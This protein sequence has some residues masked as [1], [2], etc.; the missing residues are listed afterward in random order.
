[1]SDAFF[2]ASAGACVIDFRGRVLAMR[3]RNVP[4]SA[5]Q[6]PQGGITSDELPRDAV[7][8]ELREEAGILPGEVE[9][10]AEHDAWLVY[11]VPPASRNAKVGWG[12]AQRWFLLRAKPGLA[13]VPDG[14]EF[15][16]CEWLTPEELLLR[17]VAFRKPIYSRAFWDFRLLSS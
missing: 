16:T 11:E 5:W 3:R 12:Q 1:M 9:I 17:V 13:P 6:M 8:R 2:R 14:R 15:D 4:E 10:V 7:L